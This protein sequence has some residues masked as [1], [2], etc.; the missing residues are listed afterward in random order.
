MA[1]PKYIVVVGA[2][3]GGLNSVIELAA[4]LDEKVDAA[5]FIAMHIT[6]MST[7]EL[8]VQ[9]IQS[10]TSLVC[11]MAG[12]GKKIEK[13][14]VYLAVPDR[15]LLLKE[16]SMYLGKGTPEN[17]WRPSIDILFRSA[18]AAYSAR[19]IGIILS[20]L[21][22]DGM[23]GMLAIKKS[24]GTLIVQ[25]PTEAEYPDMPQ[26]VLNNM[27]VDY[28]VRLDA[29]GAIIAE[30]SKNGK[31]NYPPA[32]PEVIAEAAIAER[33]AMNIDALKELGE[34][35]LYSC[36]DCGGGLWEIK[37]ED[38]VRYRCHTGHVYTENELE[39]RQKHALENT[40]WIALRM[41]EERRN[42]LKKMAEEERSKGWVRSAEN[43]L[44][45]SVDLE[46]HIERLKK[47]LYE[48][49]D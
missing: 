46:S 16:G 5:V 29:M 35:S 15:H 28:A 19:V 40:M 49:D 26:S 7:V 44:E 47:I 25:D 27:K 48:V 2:S 11:E 13:G 45:R 1:K 12:D 32:P 17:R 4:Q 37:G 6:Q 22:E 38:S 41:M 3:A 36:P 43:K 34:K 42:L 39:L 30:K 8:L 33:V 21:M 14:H 20:G 23:A 31:D 24:G 9:R 18:A 10:S